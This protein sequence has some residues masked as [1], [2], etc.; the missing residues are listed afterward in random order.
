MHLKNGTSDRGQLTSSKRH[1]PLCDSDVHKQQTDL[2]GN[3]WFNRILVQN[4]CKQEQCIPDLHFPPP[5]DT[6]AWGQG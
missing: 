2:V 3:K 5:Q 1:R 6:K 4:I